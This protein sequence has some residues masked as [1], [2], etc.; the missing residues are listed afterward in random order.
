MN[1]MGIREKSDQMIS[2]KLKSPQ[3]RNV[4]V[5]VKISKYITKR[6]NTSAKVTCRT[7]IYTTN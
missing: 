1:Y 3:I 5:V 2:L 4:R 7:A 6:C